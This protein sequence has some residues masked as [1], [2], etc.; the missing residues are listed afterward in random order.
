MFRDTPQAQQAQQV[1]QDPQRTARPRGAAVRRALALA[2]VPVLLVAGCSS[3]GDGGSKEAA[4]PSAAP[5][6]AAPSPEPVKFTTLPDPCQSLGRDLVQEVVPK[7]PPGKN[8][9]SKDA[10]AYTSCLWSGLDDFEYRA[11][12]VSF[13]RFDSDTGLGSGDERATEYAA[14][15]VEAATRDESH[16]GVKDSPLK[17]LGDAATNVAYDTAKKDGKKSEDYREQRT[18]VRSANVVIT[19]DYSGAGFEDAKT[20]SADSIGK[21]AEKVAEKALSALD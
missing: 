5:S 3:G 17:D 18:V 6:S 21:G 1:P 15:Q 4:E 20:P 11:L 19:V 7:A 14:Q 12:S 16:K 9:G 10:D 2:A 13:R 8:L